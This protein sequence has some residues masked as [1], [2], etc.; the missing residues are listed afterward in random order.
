MSGV[1]LVGGVVLRTWG[2]E[3]WEYLCIERMSNICILNVLKQM[4]V[5]VELQDPI[6]KD[7]DIIILNQWTT[8][9]EIS[10]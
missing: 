7:E 1:G 3:T 10:I 4:T 6:Y 8:T 2:K 9:K 5:I